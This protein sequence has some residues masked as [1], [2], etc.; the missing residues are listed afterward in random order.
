[1]EVAVLAFGTICAGFPRS[2]EQP[3]NKYARYY[4]SPPTT[5]GRTDFQSRHESVGI[6]P[7]GV[8]LIATFHYLNEYLV[9]RDRQQEGR[10]LADAMTSRSDVEE[11]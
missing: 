11:K 4:V 6:V 10:F 9:K 1:M 7:P 2:N 5:K 3:L 8:L